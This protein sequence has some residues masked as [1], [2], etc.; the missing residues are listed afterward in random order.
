M[1]C[2][3]QYSTETVTQQ[4]VASPAVYSSTRRCFRQWYTQNSH[5]TTRR[6]Y[7]RH[8]QKRVTQQHLTFTSCTSKNSHAT[9]RCLHRWKTKNNH[10]T[11]RCFHQWYPQ[12]QSRNNTLSSPMKDAKQNTQQHVTFTGGTHKT[13]T[14]QHVTFTGSKHKTVTQQ[15]VAFTSGTRRKQPRNNTLP[16]PVEYA[17]SYPTIRC[18]D[19]QSRNNSMLSSPVVFAKTAPKQ[20]VAFTSG[21]Q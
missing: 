13:V 10:A 11:T 18:L 12:K 20:Q 16:S 17:N 8:T 1:R 9:S 6:L 4:H 5:A 14:Q 3:Y 15:H 19:Q 21:I 7:R 2:P